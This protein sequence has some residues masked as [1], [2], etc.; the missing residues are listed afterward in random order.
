MNLYTIGFTQK[1][2]E[3]FFDQLRKNNI[4]TLIDIRLNNKSQLAG[5]TKGTD[6]KYFLKEICNIEYTHDNYLSPT[7]EILKDYKHNKISWDEYE[8][9]FRE[10][11]QQRGIDKYFSDKYLK[12]DFQLCLLCSEVEPEH[13]H[14]R[15][16]A[17]YIVK[18]AQID[19]SILHL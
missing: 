16:I 5:F 1:T 10:L 2:A 9:R 7:E 19:I 14:R 15:L 12:D 11:M 13:C 3:K 6:L 8:R 4:R 18:N 17:E